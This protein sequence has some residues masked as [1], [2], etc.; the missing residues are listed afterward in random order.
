MRSGVT[1]CRAT[2]AAGLAAGVYGDACNAIGSH[3]TR[4]IAEKICVTEQ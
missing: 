1:I 2:P 4:R 3:V